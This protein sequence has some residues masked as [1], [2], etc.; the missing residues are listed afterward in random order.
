MFWDMQFVSWVLPVCLKERAISIFIFHFS[1]LA[2][3]T[4]NLL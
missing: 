2:L 3:T 4:P 1:I